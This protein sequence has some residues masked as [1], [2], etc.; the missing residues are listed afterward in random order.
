MKNSSQQQIREFS[1]TFCNKKHNNKKK[2]QKKLSIK[3][4]NEKCLSIYFW[5]FFAYVDYVF[6]KCEMLFTIHFDFKMNCN[7]ILKSLS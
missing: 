1:L 7:S 4:K 2:T 6:W 5:Y 3:F